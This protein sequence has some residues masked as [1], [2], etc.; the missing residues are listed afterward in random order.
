MQRSDLEAAGELLAEGLDAT[1]GMAQ[2]THEAISK[3]AFLI[4]GSA[5]RPVQQI[6]DAIAGAT[7]RTVRA[8]LRGGAKYGS[9]AY[10]NSIRSD[11]PALADQ[12]GGAV[13]L[14]ALNGLIGDLL[15]ERGSH[16]ATPMTL[17]VPTASGD[18]G[19]VIL[20][21]ADELAAAYPD[22]TPKIAVFLHGLCETELAWRGLPFSRT[23]ERHVGFPQRLAGD[24]GYTPLLVRF[25]SGLHISDNG[26]QLDLLLQ[27]VMT[28]WPVPITEITLIG[29]SMGGLIARSAAHQAGLREESDH[30]G[31]GYAEL[32]ADGAAT[33]MPGAW[34]GRLR[35]VVC[36]G[37]PHFG[38]DLE[39]GVHL[40]AWALGK[41]T[42]SRAFAKLLWLRS[43][44][45]KD[46]RHGATSEADWAG[47]DADALLRQRCEDLPFVPH[48]DYSWISARLTEGLAGHLL[49]DLLV[50]TPSAS[51]VGKGR[52]IPFDI[53]NGHTIHGLTHFD[54]LDHPAVYEQLLAWVT[55]PRRIAAVSAS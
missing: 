44:G 9:R 21:N 42:E 35:H 55:R 40:L 51:G 14:G 16:L 6:H 34:T 5:G 48:A 47:L 52:Q 17:R 49:G 41:A 15:A 32:G 53:D 8:G 10:A 2:E 13:A 46:L 29:H 33:A 45:I 4:P 27:Q 22:A 18:A 31:D 54:L 26:R 30:Q 28:N 20:P 50:R 3:R 12:A 24:A 39:R 23:G 7:Y 37:T 43:D 1:A 25:N 38:A 19:S 36:L 11:A